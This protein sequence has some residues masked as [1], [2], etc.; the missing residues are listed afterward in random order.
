MTELQNMPYEEYHELF[1][2]TY[3]QATTEA[4]IKEAQANALEEQVEEL[5]SAPSK[6][7]GPRGMGFAIQEAIEKKAKEQR[8]K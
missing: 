5:E 3:L 4:G 1:Y 7:Y 8:K 6:A 2:Q